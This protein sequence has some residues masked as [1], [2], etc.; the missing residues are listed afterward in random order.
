MLLHNSNY[1][2]MHP[3]VPMADV[4]ENVTR[5][6]VPV[7]GTCVMQSAIKFCW[8]QLRTCSVLLPVLVSTTSSDPSLLLSLFFVYLLVRCK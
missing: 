4:Q 6:M 3:L 7:S 1:G 2:S 8:Y 5:K